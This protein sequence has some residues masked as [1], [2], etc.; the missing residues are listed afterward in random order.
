[1]INDE[2]VRKLREM[3]MP[4]IID[5]MKHQ[6]S[7]NAYT[8]MPFDD[9]F[10]HLIDSAYQQ[11]CSGKV[12][13]LISQSNIR[14]RNASISDIYYEERGLDKHK[15][16][17]LSTCQF[18]RRNIHA[19]FEG[20]TGSGKTY[21]ACTIGKQACMQQIRVQY[22]RTPDL[23]ILMS[24]A[25]VVQGE[26]RKLLKKYCGFGL[27]ILDEWLLEVPT[28]NER[29]FILELLERRYDSASIVFCTQYRQGEWHERLG[30]G[31]HA[32]AIMDRVVHNAVW[33]NAG[34]INMRE[35]FSKQSQY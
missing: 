30:G 35:H 20:M 4:E 9:R 19:V 3:N 14:F 17:E 7:N 13:R 22:I 16:A 15:M 5:A 27:L 33:V 24:E 26:I 31:V 2:T 8:G 23:M 29:H 21:L 18:I 25:A 6:D 28:D 32:D 10:E 12:I 11:K 34:K 1:M